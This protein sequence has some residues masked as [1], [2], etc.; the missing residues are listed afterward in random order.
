M[1]ELVK[2]FRILF[3]SKAISRERL[4]E[5]CEDHITRLNGNN[6]GGVFTVILT[7]ITAAY[8]A[9]FGDLASES[10]NLAVQEGKTIAMNES[11]AVLEKNLSDNEKLVAFTYRNNAATY[12]EFYPLGLKEYY[13][14]SLPNLEII[15]GR[16]LTVLNN[17]AA[18]FPAAFVTEYMTLQGIFIANRAAQTAAK[19]DVSAE[20]SDLA[21]TRPALCQKLTTNLLVIALEF[22]GDES[23]ADVY[24]D[25][26]ILNAAFKESE[27][28]V[29]NT[30]DPGETQNV[31]DNVTQPD[32]RLVAKNNGEEVL[33]AGF[34]ASPTEP[35]TDADRHLDPGQE[36]SGTA[37]EAGWTTEKKFLN[38]TNPGGTTG[39]YVIEKI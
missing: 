27:R 22:L 26:A 39:S 25:Q 12:E 31:F 1:I 21:T 23:K 15:S 16:Y 6:P 7:E 29:A 17:H 33:Y 20:R 35:A 2:Y 18:D 38:I 32:V 13:D 8:N 5:F 14:A 34:K 11:R 30:I 24:F 10:L 3:L 9:F 36:V 4:K 28:K 19:G 37:A